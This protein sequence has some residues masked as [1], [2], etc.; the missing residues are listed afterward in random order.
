MVQGGKA[1][2]TGQ[3]CAGIAVDR[4][5]HAHDSG[6]AGR[7]CGWWSIP[8]VD[9]FR[10]LLLLAWIGG[11]R[12]LRSGRTLAKRIRQTDRRTVAAGGGGQE[13]IM[14][15]ELANR[16]YRRFYAGSLHPYRIFENAVS[17]ALP[18]NGVLLDAG[19]GR[20][21][22]V[23]QKY[24]GKAGRLI[25]VDVVDF[26]PVQPDL[27]LFMANLGQIPLASESVDLVMSRSVFEHLEEPM[28]VY[29][30]LYRILKPGGHVVF[31]TANAWDYATLIARMIPNRFHAWIVAKTE[32]RAE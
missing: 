30:E 25:G 3:T 9:V 11:T 12:G 21:A 10:L 28:A 2:S 22:P 17:S 5:P 7:V 1:R 24:R 19:C 15:S 8:I 27:E 31:L 4:T 23:L 29:N 20:T 32:G 16:L 26:A 14:T 13:R 18:Q 6:R